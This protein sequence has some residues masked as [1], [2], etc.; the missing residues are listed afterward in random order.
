MAQKN[1]K[2]HSDET[3]ELARARVAA[4]ETQSR[5]ARD[6]GVAKSTL[7]SWLTEADRDGHQE[8]RE[9]RKEK[10]I[11][12][13]W[14][15]IENAL[16]FGNQ[17]IK[18][19]TVSQENF[20][21]I[22]ERFIE[23]LEEARQRKEIN[24]LEISNVVTALASLMRIPLKDVSTYIG[25][26]YDKIALASGDVTTRGEVKGQVT[27]RY[28][29]DITQKIITDPETARLADRLLQRA[30]NSDAGMVRAH[31]KPWP[32]AAVRPSAAPE[33]EDT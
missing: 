16:I 18:V 31:N 6:M 15:S 2:Q 17:K 28:E 8:A 13:A 21:D 27:Q 20:N 30:A 10:F 4:G 32:V 24:A 5:V 26:L 7:H 22:I 23:L 14:E 33:P 25:T 1:R 19:A 29:Y 12:K 9:K 3:K 11:D